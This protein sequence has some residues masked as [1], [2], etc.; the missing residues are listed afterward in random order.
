[1]ADD[2]AKA[3]SPKKPIKAKPAPKRKAKQGSKRAKKNAPSKGPVNLYSHNK[4]PGT[5]KYYQP[6]LK[7]SSPQYFKHVIRLKRFL[8]QSTFLS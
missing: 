2:M 1:M 7:N 4:Y 3:Q 8:A 6:N 5:S